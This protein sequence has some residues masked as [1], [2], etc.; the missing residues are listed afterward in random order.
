MAIATPLGLLDN[1]AAFG[2]DDVRANP[3]GFL[4]KNHLSAIPSGLNHYAR[5]W[6]HALFNGYDFRHDK[7]PSVGYIVSAFFGAAVISLALFAM[8]G[9]ARLIQAR[10]GA[11][12]D[13]L[14]RPEAVNV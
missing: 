12:D 14:I 9:V 7:H 1:A 3:H 11:Q 2:E 6:H 8:F 4:A 10:R 13:D 5:F